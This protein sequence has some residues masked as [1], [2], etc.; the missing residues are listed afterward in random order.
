MRSKLFVTSRFKLGK[1]A[2]VT[3]IVLLSWGIAIDAPVH[4]QVSPIFENLTLSPGFRPDPQSLRGISGGT[5]AT[6]TISERID[7][8]TGPCVGFV[9]RQPDHLLT[10]TEYFDY[11]SVEVQSPE[12]T[13]L[14]ISGPGG[15]WCNDDLQGKNP[16]IIGKWLAGEYKVWVG[17]Y[18]RNKFHPYVVRLSETRVAR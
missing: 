1:V 18:E 3:A 13:T 8:S 2:R 4:S 5:V 12:D 16:G 14:V 7:T 11:L 15:T 9:D 10:L 6:R 17:S